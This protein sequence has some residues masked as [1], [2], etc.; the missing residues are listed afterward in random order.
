M[1]DANDAFPAFT[2]HQTPTVIFL[3]SGCVQD[4][5]V[6]S[7]LVVPLT[8]LAWVRILDRMNTVCQINAALVIGRSYL[9]HYA[10]ASSNV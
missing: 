9:P 10:L 1:K 5:R 6:M 7:S 8:N 4:H 2:S 3:L